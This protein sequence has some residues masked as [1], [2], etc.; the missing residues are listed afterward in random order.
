[1]GRLPQT[2]F[3][4]DEYFIYKEID[5]PQSDS[6]EKET[7]TVKNQFPQIFPPIV[8]RAVNLIAQLNWLQKGRIIYILYIS[9]ALTD[10]QSVVAVVVTQIHFWNYLQQLG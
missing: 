9:S 2:T 10:S 1:M 8:L 6:S 7:D 4:R 3:F 5:H